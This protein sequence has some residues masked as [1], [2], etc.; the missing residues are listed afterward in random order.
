MSALH[1]VAV[2]RQDVNEVEVLDTLTEAARSYRAR[3]SALVI[4]AA[5]R[6]VRT[7]TVRTRTRACTGAQEGAKPHCAAH[8]SGV[9]AR[10]RPD[11]KA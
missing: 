1:D 11:G 5:R 8:T 10:V 6:T 4:P 3:L 2:P 7:R 9:D